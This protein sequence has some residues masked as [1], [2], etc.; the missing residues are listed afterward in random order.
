MRFQNTDGGGLRLPLLQLL[1]VLAIS[2]S[3]RIIDVDCQDHPIF[4]SL[5]V[6][7]EQSAEVGLHCRNRST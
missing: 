6:E 7:E 1:A 5:Q 2:T 3:Y 4:L